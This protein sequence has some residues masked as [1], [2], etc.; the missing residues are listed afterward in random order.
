MQTFAA[1][2]VRECQLGSMQIEAVGEMAIEAVA[3]DGG[4][5]PLGG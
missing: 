2:R 5:Q 4:I 3:E 1:H